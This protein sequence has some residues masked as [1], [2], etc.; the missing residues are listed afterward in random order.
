MNVKEIEAKSLLRN[1]RRIDSWFVAGYGMNLYRGCAH[2]CAY[3]DGR[4]EKYRVEGDFGAE[5]SVKVNALEVLR[6]E[7]RRLPKAPGYAAELWPQTGGVENQPS[8]FILLG[9]G[10]GDGYQPLDEKYRLTRKVLELLEEKGLPV[11]VLTKSTLVLRDADILERVNGAARA[12]VSFSISSTDD[13][14]SAIFEPGVPPPSERL[15]ALSALK[16][17]GIPCG[18]FLMPV[19][20]FVTDSQAMISRAVREAADAGA[21]FVTFGGMTLKEGRQKEHFLRALGRGR[22]ELVER[23][24]AL[25]AHND[26][27]GAAMGDYYDRIGRL[28]GAAAKQYGVPPRMPLSVFQGLLHE[29]D[30]VI[31]LLEHI[32]EMLQIEGASSPFRYAAS[33]VSRS[34]G[35]V[36]A[37]QG[38]SA[39]KQS[40]SI[41]RAIGEIVQTGTCELYEDLLARISRARTSSL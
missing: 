39:G 22:P 26:R 14:Q 33:R 20:P 35:P 2:D 5:V 17:R 40:D 29:K 30:L 13:D 27:W 3:C 31:V 7:L 37:E 24:R 34:T 15:K 41:G 32:H 23:C 19:I 25:Y 4:A 12:V 6:R 9:G 21:D 16:R 36:S 18:V 38:G 11:H 1:M 8:G 10:V 28:F